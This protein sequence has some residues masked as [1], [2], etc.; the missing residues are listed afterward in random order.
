MLVGFTGWGRLSGKLLRVQQLPAS[1][2]CSLGIAVIIFV[3]GWLNLIHAIYSSILIGLVIIGLLLY[4]LLRNERPAN[5]R[6]LAFWK[7]APDWS[8]IFIIVT[9]LIL[10]LRVV[11]TVRLAT[12]HNYDDGTAYLAFPQKMLEAHRFAPDPFSDRR[13]IS[14]L[15]GS[16]LLQAIV[17]ATTSPSNIGMAD[18]TLG[19]LLMFV[20]IF[21]LG[22]AFEL[23]PARIAFMA[24][25]ACLIPQETFNL[26]FSVLPISLLLAMIWAI[27]ATFDPEVKGGWRH[28]AMMGAIGGGLLCLKSTFLPYIGAVALFPYLLHFWDKKRARALNLPLTAGIIALLVAASWMIA[29]RHES[30]TL[31]FPLLGYGVDY[32]SYGHFINL[33]KFSGTRAIARVFLQA[34]VL[35]TLAGVQYSAGIRETRFRLSFSILLAAAFAITAFNYES[36]GDY[37]WRYNFPQFLT[38]ILIFFTAAAGARDTNLD[39][40][41][42]KLAHAVAAASLVACIFYYDVAGGHFTPFY[43]MSNEILQ[44][45]CDLKAS[46]SGQRLVSPQVRAEYRAMEK[47]LPPNSVSLDDTART[48]LLKDRM[49]KRFLI[50]DWPG[51]AGP[52]PGWPYSKDPEA[53]TNYLG[54]SSVHYIVFDYAYAAWVDMH[55]CQALVNQTHYSQLDHALELLMFVTH[56]QFERLRATHRSLYDDGKIA[57]IDL[58]STAAPTPDGEDSWTLDTSEA[59]MCFQISQHYTATHSSYPESSKPSACEYKGPPQYFNNRKK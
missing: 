26:T 13:V 1:V 35:L 38:A 10:T 50:D 31:L 12:Y 16:Y 19:L 48:F 20:A 29:M 42:I 21:D 40:D 17:I 4:Y 51:A 47:G 9:I 55:S 34:A 59:Q 58:S 7:R 44:Y 22:I 30:G 11:A 15:G 5:Y 3:G 27:Y 56:H 41:P 14:S 33:A 45:P 25:V 53:V 46:L 43:E 52:R 36:G 32:S 49:G 2:A 18:R 8:R 24:F 39:T 28:A 54:Q 37:I 57:I 23:A 6:W